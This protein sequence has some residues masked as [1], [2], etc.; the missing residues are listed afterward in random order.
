MRYG[1]T[2][3]DGDKVIQTVNDY[4]KE[5]W[6][7]DIGKRAASPHFASR[8]V[9]RSA[10]PHL[11]FEDS[12]P[13][14]KASEQRERIIVTVR[15]HDFNPTGRWLHRAIVYTGVT[16]GRKLVVLVGAV[17]TLAMVVKRVD[18]RRR[19]TT[20]RERLQKAGE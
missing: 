8:Q 20:L 10:L 2:F 6:N 12:F 15:K 5:V 1:I 11:F 17:K 19:I 16:R 7:G 14:N 3:R 9:S 4:E 18:S 13:P